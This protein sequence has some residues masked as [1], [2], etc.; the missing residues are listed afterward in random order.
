MQ[1]IWLG[2]SALHLTSAGITEQT[3]E[4]P[5]P[6]RSRSVHATTTATLALLLAAPWLAHAQGTNQ[7]SACAASGA[8]GGDAGAPCFTNIDDILGGQRYLLRNDDLLVNF[9]KRVD[10]KDEFRNLSLDTTNLKP[11]EDPETAFK[12]SFDCPDGPPQQ[13]TQLGRIYNLKNDV[14]VSYVNQNVSEGCGHKLFVIDPVDNKQLHGPFGGFTSIEPRLALLDANLDGYDDILVMGFE[15]SVNHNFFM[16]IYAPDDP[17]DKTSEPL[18]KSQTEVIGSDTAD[19]TPR[20]NVVTGDFNGDGAQDIAWAGAAD[21][22]EVEIRFASVCPAAHRVVLGTTCSKAFD[23]VLSSQTIDTSRTWTGVS[24]AYA[25]V[26]YSDVFPRIGLAAGDLDGVLNP[27]T[28]VADAELVLIK[29][30]VAGGE[31][32]AS[33]YDFAA[34]LT[35]DLAGEASLP[36][37]EALDVSRLPPYVVSGRLDWS[38]RQ[39]QVVTGWSSTFHWGV[40]ILSFNEAL[41]MAVENVVRDFS[42]SNVEQRLRGLAVGRFDPLDAQDGGLDFNQQIALLFAEEDFFTG[43]DPETL[44]DIWTV[45]PPSFAPTGVESAKT[46]F[47]KSNPF[48]T[49]RQLI[50]PLVAGDLQGRSL[51]LGPPEK[52]TVVHAQIDT[53]LGLPPMH[54]DYIT[55][56][57]GAGPEVYNVSVYPEVFNTAYQFTESQ[58]SSASSKSTTSYTYSTKESFEEKVSYGIPDIGGVSLT[59]KQ[60]ATQK[61]KSTVASEYDTYSGNSYS[62]NAATVFDDIVGFSTKRMNIYS[63][64][65]IGHTICPA[66][67]PACTAAEML[68]LHVQFSGVD[69]VVTYNAPVAASVLEWYQPVNEPGTLFSYPGNQAQLEADLPQQQAQ[70]SSTTTPRFMLLSTPTEWSTSDDDTVA[71]RWST[72]SSGTNTVGSVSNHSF[73]ASA[74]VAGKVGFGNFGISGSASFDYNNS[75]SVSTLNS[76]TLK[77][78]ESDGVTLDLKLASSTNPNPQQDYAGASYI[79]GLTAPVGVIQDDIEQ[80]SD[81]TLP[82]AGPLRVASVADM[83]STDPQSSDW[84]PIAYGGVPDVALNH[85]QRWNQT[86]PADPLPE[87]VWF[88]CPVGYTS[89]SGSPNCSPSTPPTSLDLPQTIAE[90]HFYRI[91]GLFVTPGEDSS[92]PPTTAA[93]VGDILTLRA[94]IYNYSL[95]NMPDGTEVHVAFYAQS[96]D[97]TNG[98]FMSDPANPDGFAKA[99][100]IDE[101]TLAPIPAFCGGIQAGIDPCSEQDAP[102]NWAFAETTWDTSSL[103]SSEAS[104]WKLWLVTWMEGGGDLVPEIAGH[105]LTAIP[106]AD[107]NSLADVPIETYSNNMGFYNQL[108]TLRPPGESA[109]GADVLAVAG[110]P[111]TQQ[112]QL[113]IAKVRVS[114]K[115]LRRGAIPT[116]RATL[117]ASQALD[118]VMV[119]FFDGDPAADSTMFDAEMIPHIPADQPFVVTVPYRLQGCGARRV[120]VD[121]IPLGDPV[122][123]ATAHSRTRNRGAFGCS[124]I[125]RRH[126]AH[127]G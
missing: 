63:Y 66:S 49:D 89:S 79:F 52:A 20:S 61:H 117:R 10:G 90:T 30:A 57:E 23:F 3:K 127:R 122:V 70:G 123:P 105:G 16:Q 45:D 64:P 78:D 84:W 124:P 14:I 32:S 126:R 93:T 24:G 37:S 106:G 86:L 112:P 43:D 60:A 33:V 120:Y 13:S 98:Q 95:A 11:T 111:T 15:S 92:G 36:D 102:R 41:E 108:F 73:D 5:M 31:A 125:D 83:T 69:N 72:G 91:K 46:V 54:V 96:W 22:G 34:D 65:V 104:N 9:V 55:P 56:P 4:R 18:F 42:K 12:A 1:L 29:L 26:T 58:K 17:D 99:V 40:W 116:V 88:N 101:V 48:N 7:D 121:A 51:R 59:A 19:Y 118:D 6:P 35:Y 107:L 76:D 62:L 28:G 80:A 110:P 77:L 114:P 100:F 94:R 39:D 119:R 67:M 27:D 53:V 87:L 21:D 85:P 25:G 113:W 68:P 75:T 50:A 97:G 115:R 109:A 81:V 82:A 8:T 103:D 2:H 71:L 74:S 44:I 47:L 38:G